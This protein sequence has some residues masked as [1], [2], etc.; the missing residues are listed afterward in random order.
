MLA[1]VHVAPRPPPRRARWRRRSRSRATR[2]GS[3]CTEV[4]AI[5]VDIGPGLF[6]GLRV[7]IATA[8][9]IAQAL[10]VPMIGISSLDLLAL[11]RPA[12]AAG[13]IAAIID[14]RRGEVFYAFYRQ[15]P[16][17]VQR[18]GDPVVAHQRSS[19]SELLAPR[20]ERLLV[21]DGAV[22]YARRL[23]RPATVELADEGLEHPSAASLVQL[24]HAQ[25][26]REEFVQPWEL[27]PMYLRAPDAEI[28][29]S[30]RNEV[31]R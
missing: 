9:A 4:G 14:A 18:V 26:L 6:T 21:G 2:P 10:R 17:G 25:A 29:W 30:V 11:P 28:N 20:E 3:S 7:G 24:A 1:S 8:K 5:A 16:G 13:C 15:V 19:P 27:A 12:S 22:R 23:R 31:G